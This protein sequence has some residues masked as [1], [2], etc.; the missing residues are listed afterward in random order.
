MGTKAWIFCLKTPEFCSTIFNSGSL[1]D[2]AKSRFTWHPIIAWLF[3]LTSASYR[4]LQKSTPS[5]N[6]VHQIFKSQ[7]LFPGKIT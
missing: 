6:H 7:V 3:L 2:Q 4:F 1:M 5:K